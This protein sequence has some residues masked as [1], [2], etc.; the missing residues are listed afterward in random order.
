MSYLCLSLD[1]EWQLWSRCGGCGA[2]CH[3]PP[4]SYH[5]LLLSGGPLQSLLSPNLSANCNHLHRC[6]GLTFAQRSSYCKYVPSISKA[7]GGSMSWLYIEDNC[8]FS[9]EQCYTALIVQAV[10]WMVAAVY[11]DNVQPN[12]HGVRL[13]FWYPFL[14]GYWANMF[15]AAANAWSQQAVTGPGSANAVLSKTRSKT[16]FAT[17]DVN[18]KV[19]KSITDAREGDLVIRCSS[20]PGNPVEQHKSGN[21]AIAQHTSVHRHSVSSGFLRRRDFRN[22][23]AGDQAPSVELGGRAVAQAAVN[24]WPTM[25]QHSTQLLVQNSVTVLRLSD[26]SSEAPSA[27]VMPNGIAPG[28][29]ISLQQYQQ[30]QQQAKQS[31]AASKSW[32]EF[33]RVPESSM[34]LASKKHENLVAATAVVAPGAVGGKDAVA[35]GYGMVPVVLD[36]GVLQE[37]QRMKTAWYTGQFTDACSAT[38]VTW[39]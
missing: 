39:H 22:S 35:S 8:V 18:R 17:T 12:K 29:T 30:M 21:T 32:W 23:A 10:A 25:P 36:P 27:A 26:A 19:A 16:P 2:A 20:S 37:E 11:L 4:T 31:S 3:Q 24:R 1:R 7:A 14:P 9:I 5:Q 13:P 6:A 28:Q 15:R 33:W 34:L 38:T